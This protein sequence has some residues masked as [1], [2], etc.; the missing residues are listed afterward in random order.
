M[1]RFRALILGAA[2]AAFPCR[3]LR[4]A[5]SA[6]TMGATAARNSP[7]WSSVTAGSESHVASPGA[8]GNQVRSTPEG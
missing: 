4:F 2:F 7:I 3:L 1:I 5:V 8:S 6:P